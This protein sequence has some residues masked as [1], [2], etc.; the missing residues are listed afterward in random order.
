MSL[1]E[2]L[3][4]K[5]FESVYDP[6]DQTVLDPH[7]GH[8]VDVNQAVKRS[9]LGHNT[10][11]VYD[12]DRNRQVWVLLCI[13]MLGHNICLVCDAHRNRQVWVLLCVAMLRHNTCLVYG[14]DKPTYH[15]HG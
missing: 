6:A 11:L 4:T 12:T 15:L 1:Y 3:K 2:A 7:N 5:L 9:L 8:R 10:C 13:A 14:T